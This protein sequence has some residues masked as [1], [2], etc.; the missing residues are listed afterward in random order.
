[1][2]EKII[3]VDFGSQYTQLI[4][5]RVREARV[6]SEILAWNDP[7]LTEP[8]VGTRGYILSGGPMSAYAQGAPG[9]TGAL[10][11][12]QLPILGI[13]Y[14]MQALAQALEGEV[15]RAGEHEYGL[16]EIT[17]IKEN[18]LLPQGNLTVWM[19]HGDRITRPPKGWEVLASSANCPIA[20]VGD[21]TK[22]RFGLQF[23]PEV[24][25][26]PLGTEILRRFVLEICGCAPDWTPESIIQQSVARIRQH[27]A[28]KRVL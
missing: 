16:A 26:T 21:L 10:L 25:H 17:V 28:G 19:S 5:R 18:P 3:I 6:Y 24:R 20:A 11:K 9:I 2:T 23:H 7:K 14:G 13:C 4:A 15:S 8:E 22:K 12:S 1:M 27:A